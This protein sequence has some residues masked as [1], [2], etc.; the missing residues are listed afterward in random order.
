MQSELGKLIAEVK[1][2]LLYLRELGVSGLSADIDA[3]QAPKQIA[4][5]EE[6]PEPVRAA[7]PAD[8]AGLAGLEAKA[9]KAAPARPPTPARSLRDTLEAAKLSHRS[10]PET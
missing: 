1:Q 7:P 9:G 6:R 2:N 3:L 10:S 8:A 5:V 4:P